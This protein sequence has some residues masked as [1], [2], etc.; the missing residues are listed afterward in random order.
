MTSSRQSK[1][2]VLLGIGHTN[3]HVVREWGRR[4]IPGCEL[5]CISNYA[6][7]TYSGMLPAVLAGQI[8]EQKMQIDLPALCQRVGAQ[9][10]LGNVVELKPAT[11]E[12]VFADGGELEFDVLSVGIGSIPSTQGMTLVDEA[13]LA[14]KP[15]QTFLDRLTQRLD[16]LRFQK[17]SNPIW[18]NIIGGGVAGCEVACCL[19]QRFRTMTAGVFRLRLIHGAEELL[20]NESQGLKTRMRAELDRRKVELVLG[21]NVREVNLGHIYLDDGRQLESDLSL[22][23]TGASAP[24]L[25]GHFGLPVDNDGFLQTDACLQS[26]SGRP[27]FAVGDT[28]SIVDQRVPKAGVY[29]VRQGPVLWENIHRL[30]EGRSLIPFRPQKSFLKLINLGDGRAAGEWQ[31]ISFSGRWVMFLKSAIDGA[32]VAKFETTPQRV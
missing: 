27:I 4:P 1:R 13:C 30:V 32:F 25:L 8:P 28:G 26:T 23:V 7:S 9:L 22:I 24:P 20:G 5:A 19:D 10:R 6:E 29:A 17:G 2:I 16:R 3:A 31:G 14:I 15:M 21:R 11:N 12:L 18:I